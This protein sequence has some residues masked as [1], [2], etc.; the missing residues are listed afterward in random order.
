MK[1]KPEDS[2]HPVKLKCDLSIQGEMEMPRL[3][4]FIK[5]TIGETEVMVDVADL[6]ASD[7]SR[8]GRGWTDALLN[9]RQVREASRS[10]IKPN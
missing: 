6:P 9:H 7:L 2:S 4:N 10:T 8:I 3:P 1:N 5:F